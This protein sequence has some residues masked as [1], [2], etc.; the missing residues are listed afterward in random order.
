MNNVASE[1]AMD[2][3]EIELGRGKRSHGEK[4]SEQLDTL[5]LITSR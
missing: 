1:S 4:D 3:C 5:Q 2:A